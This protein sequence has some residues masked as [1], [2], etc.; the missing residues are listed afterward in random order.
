[1]TF[2][3]ITLKTAEL[4]K[5]RVNDIEQYLLRLV[6]EC[7]N[8]YGR[9][10]VEIP[11]IDLGIPTDHLPDTIF[12]AQSQGT[13]CYPMAFIKFPNGNKFDA[14]MDKHRHILYQKTLEE[15][16]QKM[17]LKEIEKK[18]GCKIELVSEK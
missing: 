12:E 18:L 11:R 3:S 4:Y 16:P 5:D 13:L 17:T 7:E 6:Y 9:Y 1:M 14:I 8:N 15:Y 10:E 2:K